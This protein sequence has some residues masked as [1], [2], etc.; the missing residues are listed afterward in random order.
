STP[1]T[2]SCEYTRNASL[3]NA[4]WVSC[5]AAPLVDAA[6]T[7]VGCRAITSVAKLGPDSATTG[8]PGSS[9]R[10]TSVMTT[11]DPRSMPFVATTSVASAGTACGAPL[12]TV[13]STCDG[14]TYT[15][16]SAR[17]VASPNEQV[18]RTDGLMTAPGRKRGLA[19]RAFTASTTS[20][21]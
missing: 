15:T 18:A 10:T 20:R 16:S 2:S 19:W 11:S 3:L 5:A 21:S 7:A 17:P 9:S 6:T 12:S 14:V 4:R 8:R 1:T 13:R